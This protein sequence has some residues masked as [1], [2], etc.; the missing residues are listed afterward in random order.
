MPPKRHPSVADLTQGE[1]RKIIR[2]EVT[3]ICDEM[4]ASLNTEVAEL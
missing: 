4:K 2:D 1:L 3:V